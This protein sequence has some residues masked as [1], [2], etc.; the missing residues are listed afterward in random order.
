MRESILKLLQQNSRIS[1]SEIAARLDVCEDEVKKCIDSLE[2]GGVIKGY[3]AVI[4]DEALENSAVKAI[5]EV[6]VSPSRDGGF[7][8]VAKKIAKFSQVSEVYLISGGYD[9][10]L[11]VNGQTL[12]EVAS[13]V[14]RKLSTIDGV[15][16][17][18]TH[19]L[20]KKYKQANM[21]LHEDEDFERLKITP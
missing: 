3:T 16:S 9:L 15:T 7:D 12:N 19:F 2:E 4:N 10:R 1:N 5:I 20:L 14:A 17:T 18:R 8:P 11:V 6:K 21:I 13:F